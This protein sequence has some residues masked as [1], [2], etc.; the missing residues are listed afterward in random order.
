MKKYLSL[1][2]IVF[3]LGSLNASAQSEN[4]IKYQPVQIGFIYPL[5]TGGTNSATSSYHFSF[6][7]L[8]GVTG[9][10][11]GMDLSSL[12]NVNTY[13][14]QGVQFAG[15]LNLAGLLNKAETSKNVQFAGVANLTRSGHSTQ[16][17][18]ITNVG[19][20]AYAQ[21]SGIA[22]LAHKSNFQMS[23]IN[24]AQN[25]NTQLGVVNLLQNNNFQLGVV[26]V[27]QKNNSQ[28]GVVNLTR[29]SNFQLGIVNISDTA[30]FMFGLLNL[31]RHGGMMQVEASY[32][33]FLEGVVSF[34]SGTSRLYGILSGSYNF[35]ESYWAFGA[36]IGTGFSFGKFGLNLEAMQYSIHK[37]FFKSED[38]QYNGLVQFKPSISYSFGKFQIFGGP[39]ANMSIFNSDKYK[40]MVPYNLTDDETRK[41]STWIGFSGGVRFSIF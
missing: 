20:I 32:D 18:G 11:K 15:I 17:A 39:N 38:D 36:G 34:K 27:A 33:N 2:L 5:S 13:S 26:N 14:S 19:D 28:I 12:F 37:D 8:G 31:S 21:I 40:E 1:L 6:N 22:N 29:K 9:R 30:G 16:F 24:I 7:A 25:A 41:V 3:I 35:S 23:I 10:T 4:E